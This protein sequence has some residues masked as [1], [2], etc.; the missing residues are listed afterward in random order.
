[1]KVALLWVLPFA[2]EFSLARP[3]PD[4]AEDLLAFD[5]GVPIAQT[6]SCTASEVCSQIYLMCELH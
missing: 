2:A 1:M 6:P 3:A 5:E 4:E